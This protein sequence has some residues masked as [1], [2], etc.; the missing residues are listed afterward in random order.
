M[1]EIAVINAS[2]LMVLNVP[3]Y[4]FLTEREQDRVINAI[5]AAVNGGD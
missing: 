5:Q 3:M 2:P 4:P 1:A